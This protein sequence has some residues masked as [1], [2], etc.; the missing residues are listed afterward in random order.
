MSAFCSPVR[1]RLIGIN[2]LYGGTFGSSLRLPG[3]NELNGQLAGML[4]GWYYY[5]RYSQKDHWAVKSV[6]SRHSPDLIPTPSRPF[7]RSASSC[8][9]T[10]CSRACSRVSRHKAMLNSF[11]A[12]HCCFSSFWYVGATRFVRV[13]YAVPQYTVIAS[14]IWGI[15]HSSACWTSEKHC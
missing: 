10:P 5:R 12:H 11:L 8:F 1:S 15:P 14:R 4:Q 6:V 2:R 7:L 9:W 3:F 13:I